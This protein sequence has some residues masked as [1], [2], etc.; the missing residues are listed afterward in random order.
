MRKAILLILL[1]LLGACSSSSSTA[2]CSS[3]DTPYVKYTYDSDTKLC[4]VKKTVQK[5]F[6]GNSIAEDG[7]NYCNCPSDV[8][9]THPQFGCSGSQGDYLEKTC[10]SN[11]QC[12]FLKNNKVVEQTKK[13]QIDNSDVVFDALFKIDV[14]FITNTEDDNRIAVE[15]TYFNNGDNRNIRDLVVRELTLENSKLILLSQANYNEP[16][17]DLGHRFTPKYL[18]IQSP[19]QYSSKEAIKVKLVVSYTKETLNSAGEITKT[20][21]K[22]ETLSTSI[23]TWE[24]INP[25]LFED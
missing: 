12:V 20:E 19:T 11:Q 17:G 1:L 9:K 8:S 15:L 14:P 6:C 23:G 24:V 4:V 5:D 25:N 22:L 7:E 21:E 10:N 18:E 2:D 13:V 3:Q 16:A